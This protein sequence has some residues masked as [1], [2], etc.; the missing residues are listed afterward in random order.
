MKKKKMCIGSAQINRTGASSPP[1]LV[2]SRQFTSPTVHVFLYVSSMRDEN[3]LSKIIWG[4][5]VN[6]GIEGWPCFE[7]FFVVYSR[8]YRVD[9]AAF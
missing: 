9:L 1:L 8:T 3:V 6:Y 7:F 5:T 4:R 2:A